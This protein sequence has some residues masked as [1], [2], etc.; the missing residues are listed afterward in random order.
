M[1]MDR[2]EGGT[3]AAAVF[4]PPNSQQRGIREYSDRFW[5]SFVKGIRK[6]S[7]CAWFGVSFVIKR[8]Q[9]SLFAYFWNKMRA[10]PRGGDDTSR[11]LD[12]LSRF[13]QI[14]DH[15]I[16]QCCA[17]V[18]LAGIPGLLLA[19]D[20]EMRGVCDWLSHPL[21]LYTSISITLQAVTVYPTYRRGVLCRRL[22]PIIM[23]KKLL[24]S[25]RTRV[26]YT[27]ELQC[28]ASFCDGA[29][30]TESVGRVPS[31]WMFS[32]GQVASLKCCW[33]RQSAARL[34]D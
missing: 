34:G 32:R 11:S 13:S 1:E 14:V 27:V 7:F 19:C 21:S 18:C 23:N 30:D 5:C 9:S 29:R 3:V 25:I 4:S 15:Y 10:Q 16:C 2:A 6:L 28:P 33:Q 31:L 24:H 12:L 8:R 17:V 22:K 20:Y 26:I